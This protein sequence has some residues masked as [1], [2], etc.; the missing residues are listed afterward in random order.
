MF[1]HCLDVSVKGL[2]DFFS[3]VSSLR[4]RVTWAGSDF[5]HRSLMQRGTFFKFHFTRM[6]SPP[7]N[8]PVLDSESHCA[9]AYNCNF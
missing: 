7:N 4:R 1:I 5:L 8:K 9:S 6:N 3:H 2:T